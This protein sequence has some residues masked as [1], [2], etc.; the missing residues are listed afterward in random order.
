MSV[1]L[2]PH[3]SAYYAVRRTQPVVEECASSAFHAT[4]N[5]RGLSGEKEYTSG[6][7]VQRAPSPGLDLQAICT[8]GA[9]ERRACCSLPPPSSL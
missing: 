1:E 3:A 2:M 7:L 4:A 5:S 9:T 8:A 6:G